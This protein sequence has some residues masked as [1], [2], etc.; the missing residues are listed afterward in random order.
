MQQNMQLKKPLLKI[1][2]IAFEMAQFKGKLGP[3]SSNWLESSL[4][5]NEL[6]Q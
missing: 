6:K 3:C 4:I 1:E 2:T 5:M